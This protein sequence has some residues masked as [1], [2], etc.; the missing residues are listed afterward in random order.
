MKDLGQIRWLP[1]RDSISLSEISRKTGYS[2]N[3]VQGRFLTPEGTDSKY[4]RQNQNIKIAPY[5]VQLIKAQQRHQR[6]RRCPDATTLPDFPRHFHAF[7]DTP[8][9][10][11]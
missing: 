7:V 2:R 4:E 1:Y 9:N 5:S 8:F 11:C 10:N 3:T 6:V